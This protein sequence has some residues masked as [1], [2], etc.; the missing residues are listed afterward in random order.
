MA[1]SVLASLGSALPG[2]LGGWVDAID[3]SA[4]SL[5]L[6]AGAGVATLLLGLVLLFVL[7]RPTARGGGKGGAGRVDGAKRDS[8]VFVGTCGV[9]KTA[10]ALKV[11]AR[12]HVVGAGFVGAVLV[13]HPLVGSPVRVCRLPGL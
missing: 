1:L 10:L 11:R 8:V 13:S 5:G 3:H 2:P 7:L 12:R 6:P 4:Q 9:G